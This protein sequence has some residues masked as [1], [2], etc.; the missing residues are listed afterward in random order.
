MKMEQIALSEGKRERAIIIG[1]GIGGLLT[2]RVLADY[3]TDV[4]IIDKDEFPSQPVDRTGTPQGFHPHRFTPRGSMILHQLFPGFNQDLLTHGAASSL[5][6]SIR[7][8][9]HYGTI[10]FTNEEEDVT[11]S[12][13]LMEWVIRKN[14]DQIANVRFLT[15]HDVIRLQTSADQ[16]IVVGVH[17]RDR[18]T[19]REN[20]LAADMVFDVSGRGSKLTQW[21]AQMG[22]EVPT[23]DRLLVSLAYST[24]RYRAPK[25]IAEKWDVIRI[26]GHPSNQ[27]LTGVFS[28]IENNIAEMILYGLGGTY[29]TTDIKSYEQQFSQLASPIIAEIA[30]ELEPITPPRGYRIPALTRQRFEQM[31][32]WPAG[33][34][35]LGDALCNF[36][37]IFGQ[38]MTLAAIEVEALE[39][40]L[41]EQEERPLPHFELSVLQKLQEVIE[42]AWWFNCVADLS[43]SKVEYIGQPLKGIEFAQKYLEL[44]LKQA[45]V[46]QNI[47]LYGLYWAVNSLLFAPNTVFDPQLIAAVFESSSVEDRK[48]YNRLTNS[49]HP[50]T[51]EQL[52]QI[53]PSFSGATFVDFPPNEE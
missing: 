48:W 19:K 42:P 3:Y 35:V 26:A 37:P 27:T 1:G 53:I 31:K 29:P 39:N 51:Q 46:N 11:C 25:E 52:D 5:N 40:C 41:S 36:D 49:K 34:I 15:K 43:W 4:L 23:P 45:T 38:G 14:V 18:V 33:L 12:R 2:A 6:K 24:R 17:V 8:V 47:P 7:Q 13:A 28:M 22:Y 10:E 44:Y 50:I 32:H 21:L 20:T 16:T 9:N 30:S